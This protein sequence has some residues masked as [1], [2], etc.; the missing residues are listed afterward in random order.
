VTHAAHVDERGRVSD[1]LV[2]VGC[3]YLLRGQTI[4]ERCPE[5]GGTVQLTL[6]A[7]HLVTWPPDWI[8]R[9]R[10][11][12]RLLAGAVAVGWAGMAAFSVTSLS[13]MSG[14]IPALRALEGWRL[15]S[16]EWV[17]AIPLLIA[18]GLAVWGTVVV[19]FSE[20]ARLVGSERPRAVRIARIGIVA[21]V[22]AFVVLA[23]TLILTRGGLRDRLI[24]VWIALFASG[25]V[26]TWNV[27]TAL[28]RLARRIPDE[29]LARRCEA[30]R[31]LAIFAGALASFEAFNFWAIIS[32]LPIG[33][34]LT[35]WR[36]LAVVDALILTGRIA[37]LVTGLL[38]L[39]V[40]RR[41]AK[42]LGGIL[43]ES[44]SARAGSATRIS[45]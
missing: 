45:A 29:R 30:F 13:L 19:T 33:S 25:M 18:F 37:L 27:C 26:A 40:L 21:G 23:G 6:D 20:A 31:W 10:F 8:R 4:G 7:Q 44:R 9:L 41:Y 35:W 28:A 43:E 24:W 34:R 17:L 2:C 16:W 12:L 38:A 39:G 22:A 3:G 1:E 15:W 5:C 11:G 36:T 42:R 14:S 32:W